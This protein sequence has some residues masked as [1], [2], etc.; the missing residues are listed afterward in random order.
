VS[1][2]HLDFTIFPLLSLNA[3]NVKIGN[4]AWAGGGNMAEIKTLKLGLELFPLFRKEFR[5]KELTLEEPILLLVKHQGQANWDFSKPVDVPAGPATI[6]SPRQSLSDLHLGSI[7]IKNGQAT[8]KDDAL[9]EGKSATDINVILKAPELSTKA[10]ITLSLTYEGKKDDIK[11]SLGKPLAF[12]SG[13]PVD[14]DLQANYGGLAFTWKGKA[15]RPKGG[16]PNF[17][18]LLTIP[19]FNT[20]DFS[21]QKA[22]QASA[23]PAAPSPQPPSNGSR[24]SD[25]PINLSSLARA[26]ADLQVAIGKLILPKTALSDIKAHLA[27][28]DGILQLA[29]EPVAAYGGTIQLALAANTAGGMRANFT[30]TRAEAEPFLH[31]F[32]NYDRLSGTIDLTTSLAA[33]GGS[34]RAL[35]GS[36]SGTGNVAFTNGKLKGVNLAGLL[37]NAKDAGSEDS[38]TDFTTLTGR[39]TIAKGIVS[40]HD[41]KMI[42]PLLRV[43][44]P[45]EVDLPEWQEHFLLNPA[46]VASAQDQGG[47]VVPVKVDGPINHPHYQADL[48]AALEENLKNPA[49]LRQ[50]VKDLKKKLLKGSGLQ[51]LLR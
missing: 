16:V 31:D 15:Q 7:T 1:I 42:S 48:K 25:A 23:S 45:G 2:E 10:E 27:L 36:L 39:V 4:P 21:S 30:A 41:F 22:E 32:A 47:I 24:W 49:Q 18:G 20:A 29:C 46:L 11:L 17:T 33:M 51:N 19:D 35:I 26:N 40:T 44:G 6:S 28:K 9:P 34:E 50:T 8:Y 37:R 12:Q 5:L 14:V 43:T 38:A 13:E 3:Q